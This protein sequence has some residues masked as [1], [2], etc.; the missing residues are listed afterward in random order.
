MKGVSPL[1]HT[2]WP[3]GPPEAPED[4]GGRS[5]PGPSGLGYGNGPCSEGGQVSLVPTLDSGSQ[6]RPG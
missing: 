5:S 1:S 6:N 3:Q 4:K 2:R